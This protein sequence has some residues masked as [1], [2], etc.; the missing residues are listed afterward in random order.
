MTLLYKNLGL[1]LDL[2]LFMDLL[3]AQKYILHTLGTI[4]IL[5]SVDTVLFC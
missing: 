2:D 5:L 1:D 4:L 3:L